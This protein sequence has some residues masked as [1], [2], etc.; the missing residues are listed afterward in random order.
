MLGKNKRCVCA[1][2]SEWVSERSMRRQLVLVS[3]EYVMNH[4]VITLWGLVIQKTM[5]MILWAE[6]HNECALSWR[7]WQRMHEIMYA[8]CSRNLKGKIY[9]KE[10]SLT[11]GRIHINK[12][13]FL[14]HQIFRTDFW[15]NRFLEYFLFRGLGI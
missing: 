14:E 4:W 11:G 1:S 7:G 15:N 6:L 9:I 13:R 12:Y 2:L 8:L 5:Y 3:E 10:W